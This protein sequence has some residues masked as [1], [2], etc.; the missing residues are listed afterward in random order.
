MPLVS[1]LLNAIWVLMLVYDGPKMAPTPAIGSIL[2][3][4]LFV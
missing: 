1:Y 2:V 4:I 3:S